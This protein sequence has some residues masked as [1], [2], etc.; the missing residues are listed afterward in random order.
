M[1]NQEEKLIVEIGE[2][3]IKYAVFEINNKNQ[4]KILTKKTY[5]NQSNE[6]G[7]VVDISQTAKIISKG[8]EE[9]EK[10]VNKVFRSASIIVNQ[11]DVLCTNLSGFKKL[12]GSKV[13]KGDLDYILNEAQTSIIK[14][15]E[16]NKILHILNSN[17]VLDK[18]KQTKIPVNIPGD[19]LSLH[20]TFISLPKDNLKSISEIFENN[21]LKIERIINKPFA[22]G[23]DLIT[24]KKYLKDFIIINFGTELTSIS[25]YKNSSLIFLKTFSFG[26]NSIY[27]DVVKLCSLNEN[28]IKIIVNKL[29]FNNFLDGNT[30]YLDKEFSTKINIPHIKN[31]IVARIDEMINYVYNKNKNLNYFESKTSNIYLSFDDKD[32]FKCLGNFFR[33]SI[34]TT[35]D[36]QPHILSDEERISALQGAA[37]LI[38]KGWHKEAIPFINKKKS[39]ISSFF[40]RFF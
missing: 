18:T 32:I 3:E 23:I 13:E 5:V 40:S 14:N 11:Q 21:N 19:H 31:I 36:N 25:F 7:K 29:D 26:T 39:I 8:L 12:N 37:E 22:F 2:G 17:F 33:K 1:E 10:E 4:Y 34:N 15:Q 6:K 9:I 28:E 35:A 38:F 30:K 16:K 24:K 27:N 20:M